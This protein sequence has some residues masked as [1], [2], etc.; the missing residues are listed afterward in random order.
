MTL[1]T[2]CCSM[3][4]SFRAASILLHCL[5][6]FSVQLP[7]VY[8][9]CTYIY[10]LIFLL[11]IFHGIKTGQLSGQCVNWRRNRT[12][13]QC[14]NKRGAVCLGTLW[15]GVNYGGEGCRWVC[16]KREELDLIF[17]ITGTSC[18]MN[19]VI[20]LMSISSNNIPIY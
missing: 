5:F 3:R 16:W 4:E 7:C 2:Y 6:D 10:Y 9:I 8:S 15:E 19:E 20:S 17:C 14:R 12:K 18:E 1:W 11:C 13:M